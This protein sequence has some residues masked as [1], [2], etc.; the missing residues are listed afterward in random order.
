[1]TKNFRMNM[2]QIVNGY[3]DKAARVYTT[4]STVNGDKERELT[5]Y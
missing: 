3:R 5:Y 4:P 2:C 1:V